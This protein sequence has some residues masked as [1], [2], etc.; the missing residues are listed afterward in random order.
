MSLLPTTIHMQSM[1]RA[2]R[3][4]M[5]SLLLLATSCALR[6]PTLPTRSA[7]NEA[8]SAGFSESVARD[9]ARLRKATDAY[10]DLRAAQAAGY[11][12]MTPACV[13]DSTMGGMGRH[14]FD[15]AVYDD[16][17]VIEHPEMLVYA[18]T[19][20]GASLLVAVEYVIPFQTRPPTSTP[21]RLFGQELKKHDTFKYWYLHVW[22]W[23]R[24]P[25]GLFA[26][27]NPK[28]KCS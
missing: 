9:L 13:A 11:P 7:S 3:V 1:Y 10:H 5:T 19:S 16:T 22:A 15:R 18:P 6:T 26:D 20:E 27:W 14:Y 25:A 17:L 21:P 8:L 12:T 2:M 28:V 24:N 23:E 4:A